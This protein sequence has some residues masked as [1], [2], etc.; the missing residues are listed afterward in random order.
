MNGTESAAAAG[1]AG[2]FGVRPARVVVKVGSNVLSRPDGSLDV[3][4]MSAIVDQLATLHAAGVELVLI[5]SGAVASGRG[6][7]RRRGISLG[8]LDEVSSRQLFSAV[9]QAR[10]INRYYEFFRD[11]SIICGQV[12]ATKENLATR[13]HYLNQKHCMG[14]MLGAGIIPVVNE[15]DTVS[16]TEL[17]FTDND[18]LSG[19][20]ASMMDAD[21]LIILSNIDGLYTCDPALPEAR[22]IERVSSGENADARISDKRSSLGRGG[23]STKYRIAR[24]VAGEGIAVVIA[25]GKRDNILTSLLGLT[26]GPAPAT[27]FEPA[28]RE[29]S[30]LKRWIAHGE[31]FA[32]GSVA[33]NEGAAEALLRGGASLLPVG[34][35][36]VEGQFEAGDIITV[37]APSGEI[38]ACGRAAISSAAAARAIGRKRNG[39]PLIHADYLYVYG[40]AE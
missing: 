38:I 19:L 15:N 35:T 22:L 39:S 32:K 18:E 16:V 30:S 3:T 36:D 20:I 21:A 5:S 6:E 29:P 34:V 12:L 24:R 28:E 13:R 1:A 4:R 17:M 40:R 23:M 25:N 27:V 26:P 7:F 2:I 10:L 9:G 11:H 8:S 37:A 14:V 31:S 33:V